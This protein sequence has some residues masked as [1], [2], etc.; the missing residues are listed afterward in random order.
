MNDINFTTGK[1]EYFPIPTNQIDLSTVAGEP[2]L[3]QNPGY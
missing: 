1:N 3:Q 2:T